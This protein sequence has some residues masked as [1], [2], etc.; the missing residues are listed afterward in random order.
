MHASA[1]STESARIELTHAVLN[2]LEVFAADIKNLSPSSE[3][4]FITCG[5]EFGL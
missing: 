4:H 5:P 3:K 1:V 2:G